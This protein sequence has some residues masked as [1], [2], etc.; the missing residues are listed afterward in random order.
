MIRFRTHRL[1]LFIVA[2]LLFASLTLISSGVRA[3]QLRKD[4]SLRIS[5]ELIEGEHVWSLNNQG[6]CFGEIETSFVRVNEEGSDSDY[7]N[8]RILAHTR[9]QYQGKVSTAKISGSIQLNSLN[10]VFA[11]LFVLS[12]NQKKIQVGS[13]GVL[14][15]IWAA[16]D[17]SSDP[18]QELM[19]GQLQGPFTLLG[20][21][22]EEF[23]IDAPGIGLQS[24]QNETMLQFV[25]TLPFTIEESSCGHERWRPLVIDS[26]IQT[27]SPFLKKVLPQ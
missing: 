22:D 20:I 1:Q 7:L 23:E 10:Q 18:Q 8:F 24:L 19:R 15:M 11:T 4:S 27:L 13:A 5:R 12:L 17:L 26:Y 25:Q 9:I 6:G 2:T 16:K 3:L 14:D 21:S